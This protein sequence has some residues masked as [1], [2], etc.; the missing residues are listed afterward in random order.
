[1]VSK[2]LLS[3][4]LITSLCISFGCSKDGDQ[5][6]IREIMKTVY[7]ERSREKPDYPRQMLAGKRLKNKNFKGSNLRAAMLVGADL[8]GA[9]LENADLKAAMLFGANLSG[10]MLINANLEETM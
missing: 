10:A 7:E 5:E 6:R 9:N 1:M 2:F 4:V 3:C 8:R